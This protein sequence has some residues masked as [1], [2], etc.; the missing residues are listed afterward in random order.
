VV[1]YVLAIPRYTEVY[2]I[3]TF[4]LRRVVVIRPRITDDPH[5]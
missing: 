4:L 5:R 3:I 2:M 1:L